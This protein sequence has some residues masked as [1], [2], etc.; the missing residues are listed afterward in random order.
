MGQHHILEHKINHLR[1]NDIIEFNPKE[2]T[3][4]WGLG[5][6]CINTYGIANLVPN[7]SIQVHKKLEITN[8]KHILTLFAT[9]RF[10]SK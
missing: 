6:A 4:S 8:S 2:P 10:A 7:T 9:C 3:L 5:T 1:K